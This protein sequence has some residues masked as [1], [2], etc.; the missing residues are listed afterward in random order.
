MEEPALQ[1]ASPHAEV[2]WVLSEE[3][4][5]EERSPIIDAHQSYLGKTRRNASHIRPILA[6]TQKNC[7]LPG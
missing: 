3:H 1:R 7:L 6:H 4:G 2:S 5:E